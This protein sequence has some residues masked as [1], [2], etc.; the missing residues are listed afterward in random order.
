MPSLAAQ[1]LRELLGGGAHAGVCGANLRSSPLLQSV[2]FLRK[3]RRVVV[4]KLD[5]LYEEVRSWL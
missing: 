4:I 3:S 1:G 2:P 5:L